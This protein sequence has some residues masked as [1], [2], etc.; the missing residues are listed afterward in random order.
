MWHI[1]DTVP[2]FTWTGITVEF[3]IKAYLSSLDSL[4][5]VDLAFLL[6]TFSKMYLN[7]WTVSLETHGPFCP[8]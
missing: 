5:S 8:S 3:I 6:E 4:K 7:Q 1:L 2:D